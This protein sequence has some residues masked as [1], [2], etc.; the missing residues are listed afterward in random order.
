MKLFLVGSDNEFAI[1][2]FYVKY[3]NEA[4]VEVFHFPAQTLFYKFYHRGVV[5]KLLY[6]SGFSKILKTINEEFKSRVEDFKPDIIWIFKG[7]EIF[8]Q[9]LEWARSAGI[10]LA[11]FNGDSPFIFSGRGSGNKNV[12]DSLGLYDLFLTYNNVDRDTMKSK[13]NVRSEILPFGF[14]VD[15]KLFEECKELEEVNKVCFVGNPDS[16]RADFIKKLAEKGIEIDVYGTSWNRFLNH[17]KVRIFNSV[18]HHD[19]WK[20]LSK[21]RVQLNLMRPHNTTTHNMRTFE[22]GGIGAIQLAPD[23]P[24]HRLFFKNE[25]EIFLFQTLEECVQKIEYLLKMPVKEAHGIRGNSRKRSL[26]DNYSYRCRSMQA[27]AWLK[28]IN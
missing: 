11:N 2:N 19:F 3:L 8:P 18:R 12:S 4:G 26:Q 22:C 15:E 20:T 28:E 10:K 23:T 5:N 6:R 25:E 17:S 16:I 24:D 9:S 7:M 14:D 27:L 13:F 1:E 21:Y